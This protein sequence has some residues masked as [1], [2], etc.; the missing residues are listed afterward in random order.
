MTK[1]G[2]HGKLKAVKGEGDAL[3]EILVRA[4][5]LVSTAQGCHLYMVSRDS[6]ENESVWVT[7]V[8]DSKEDHDQSLKMEG[9]RALISQA[10]PLLDGQPE[11]G[12]VLE[13]LGGI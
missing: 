1:Y 4:S 9:V 3:V 11:K 2:L 10:M 12:L 6:Q 8:W 7:E 5:S 13:V